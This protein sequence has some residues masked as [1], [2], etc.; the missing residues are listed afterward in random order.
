MVDMSD[1]PSAT[2]PHSN[3][4]L[5]RFLLTVATIVVFTVSLVM[6]G[7]MLVEK[8][9]DDAAI[10]AIMAHQEQRAAAAVTEQAEAEIV[11]WVDFRTRHPDRSTKVWIEQP[12]ST[13]LDL[14]RSAR[15][16]NLLVM[17]TTEREVSLIP[18][19]NL[20]LVT[21]TKQSASDLGDWQTRYAKATIEVVPSSASGATT[22]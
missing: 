3:D 6:G 17:I 15:E 11:T 10:A 21:V 4:R 2:A 20:G 22:H 19:D 13:V 16:Q 7:W 5:A 14:V 8:R 1:Q 12:A 9:R 18:G